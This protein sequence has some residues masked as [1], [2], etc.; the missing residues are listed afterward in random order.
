MSKTCLLA[1]VAVILASVI[2]LSDDE[3]G[4]PCYIGSIAESD[5]PKIPVGHAS[6]P[7]FEIS[8]SEPSFVRHGWGG[9]AECQGGGA[10]VEDLCRYVQ[11]HL[12]FELRVNGERIEPSFISIWQHIQETGC[13]SL[14]ERTVWGAVWTVEFP[15]G[16]FAPGIYILEG[17]WS[18]IDRPIDCIPCGMAMLEEHLAEGL[19]PREQVI[20]GDGIYSRIRVESVTLSVL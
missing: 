14:P 6:V 5:G 15:A 20:I 8:A 4:C 19:A 2:G 11:E 12:R 13:P 10:E 7:V 18:A 16:Y 9:D 17:T 3:S 1:L